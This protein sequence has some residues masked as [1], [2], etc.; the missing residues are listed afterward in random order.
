LTSS[1]TG[2]PGSTATVRSQTKT[3]VNEGGKVGVRVVDTIN[4]GPITAVV[5]AG[6][7]HG[8]Y[9]SETHVGGCASAGLLVDQWGASIPAVSPVDSG[10]WVFSDAAL[11]SWTNSTVYRYFDL[12]PLINVNIYGELSNGSGVSPYYNPVP[13]LAPLGA[14]A[15]SGSLLF[16]GAR[17]MRKK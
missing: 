8:Q 3:L 5:I 13:V 11:T 15:L 2:F 6:E 9:C 17:V 14:L 4:W 7:T 16:M 1:T 12:N 10:P